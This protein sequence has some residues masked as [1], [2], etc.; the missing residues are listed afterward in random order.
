[1]KRKKPMIKTVLEPYH[2]SLNHVI[3]DTRIEYTYIK[4]N[5]LKNINDLRLVFD[6]VIFEQVHIS[7]ST[8]ERSE[9]IDCVFKQC[10]LS[11]SQFTESIFIR[12]EFIGCKMIGSHFVESNIKDVLFQDCTNDF[13]D[14]ASCTLTNLEIKQSSFK[15]SSMYQNEVKELQLEEVDFTKT[16]FYETP[17]KSIDLSQTTLY[18][19]KTDLRSIKGAI[20][21][22]YQAVDLVHL[23]GVKIK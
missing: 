2:Q 21:S 17:L 1:M 11:G 6:T 3:D 15:D 16:T 14:I 5:E 22:E 10:D 18:E 23:L 7:S 19:L 20:I 4:N 9:F 8:L 13:I 12:C